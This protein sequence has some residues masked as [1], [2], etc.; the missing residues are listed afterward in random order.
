MRLREIERA[1]ILD[2]VRARDP[3]ARVILFGSRARDDAKGGD[4]DLL[5]VSREIGFRDEWGIRRDILDRIGWQKLD[6]LVRRPG[7]L[8]SA[9]TRIALETGVSL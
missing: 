1:A 2:P 5:V 7:Q 6:L 8:E 9:I 4:I 3:D